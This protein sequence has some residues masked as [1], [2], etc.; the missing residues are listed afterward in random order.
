MGLRFIPVETEKQI[1]QLAAIADKVWHE[2]FPCIITDEQIDYMVDKFQSKRAVTGQIAEGYEYFFLELNG[3]YIG[4]TGVHPESK[5]LFLSKLY[6]LKSYRGKGYSTRAFEFL[7]GLCDAY[8]LESIYLTV[9]RRNNHSI[10]VYKHWGFDI[11]REEVT[12][13]GQGYVMDDYIMEYVLNR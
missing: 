11:V 10:D 2:Y 9:N 5:K 1:T 7:T 12:D 4:Y 3:I 13:I 6:V 8:S